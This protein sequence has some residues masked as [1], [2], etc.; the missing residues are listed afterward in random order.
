MEYSRIYLEKHRETDTDNGTAKAETQV[1]Q[2][3]RFETV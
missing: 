1:L 3:L 2:Q